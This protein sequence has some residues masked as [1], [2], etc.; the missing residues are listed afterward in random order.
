MNSARPHGPSNKL[1][2]ARDVGYKFLANL[3]VHGVPRILRSENLAVRLVW[4]VLILFSASYGLY[5]ITNTVRD[6][7]R[8]NTITNVEREQAYSME[9]P[10]ITICTKDFTITRIID[11]TALTTPYAFFNTSLSSFVNDTFKY[12]SSQFN[13]SQDLQFFKIPKLYA[14]CVRFMNQTNVPSDNLL[15][16]FSL[17]FQLDLYKQDPQNILIKS[18]LYEYFEIYIT[19]RNVNSFLQTSALSVETVSRT[20]ALIKFVRAETE[21]KLPG[22][23]NPCYTDVPDIQ[24]NCIERCIVHKIAEAYNCS[25]PSYYEISTLNRCVSYPDAYLRTD[26]NDIPYEQYYSKIHALTQEFNAACSDMCPR[27]CTFVKYD[28]TVMYQGLQSYTFTLDFSFQDFS[29]LVITQIPKFTSFSLLSSIGGSFG[30]FIGIRFL[31]LVELLELFID[32]FCV[33]YF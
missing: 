31:S 13:A 4:I 21:T 12:K 17:L 20:G 22:P 28:S 24:V 19:N 3:S 30:L 32:L 26:I 29:S 1:N 8:F 16:S 14:N 6:F 2:K 9:F 7:Y 23:Y 33:L 27:E 25:I 15:D 11:A 18:S 10:A 5:N